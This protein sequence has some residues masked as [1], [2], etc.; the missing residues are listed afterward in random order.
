MGW[1]V[2]YSTNLQRCLLAQFRNPTDSAMRLLLSLWVGLLAGM[3]PLPATEAAQPV[4]AALN[5]NTFLRH[6]QG[7]APRNEKFT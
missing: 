6:S 5:A 3:R 1:H 4:Q 2:Q 7:R